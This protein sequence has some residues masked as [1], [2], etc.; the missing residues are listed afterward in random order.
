MSAPDM[1]TPEEWQEAFCDLVHPRTTE[2]WRN[3]AAEKLRTHDAA[4][5]AAI[6]NS[7]CRC[8]R[9]GSKMCPPCKARAIA[10]GE[11]ET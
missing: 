7:P 4:Q 2:E 11:G 6:A 3:E 8:I 5:R 1:L 10:A 9:A